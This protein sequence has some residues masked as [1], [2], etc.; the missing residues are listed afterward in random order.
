MVWKSDCEKKIEDV[1]IRFDRVHKPDGQTDGIGRT[2][3]SHR[4]TNTQL[5]STAIFNLRFPL[6]IELNPL[7]AT[8]KPQSNGPS[9]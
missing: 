5:V 1:F 7:I 6:C 8:L 2:Y 3:A 4:A 9:L